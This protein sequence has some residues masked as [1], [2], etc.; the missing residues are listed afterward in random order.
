MEL[1]RESAAV[2]S[3]PANHVS[4][5]ADRGTIVPCPLCGAQGVGDDGQGGEQ[6]LISQSL[7]Q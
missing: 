3:C 2:V 4:G 5:S 6:P 1:V 7:A